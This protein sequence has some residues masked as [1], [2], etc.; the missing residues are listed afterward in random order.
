MRSPGEARG[1]AAVFLGIARSGAG[2]IALH[3]LRSVVTIACVVAL[4]LPYAVG[5]GIS[6]GLRAELLEAVRLGPDL[7]V[8]GTRFGRPAPLPASAAGRIRAIPGVTD[9]VPRIVGELEIGSDNESAVVVGLPADHLPDTLR[10]VE[11]RLFAPGAVGELVV[12]SELAARLGLSVGDVVPPFYR[13][14]AGERLTRVVG[15]F[16]SDAPLWQAHMLYVSLET[17]RLLFSEREAVTALVV[18]CPET[19]REPVAEQIRRLGTL[20]AEGELPAVRPR[21]TTRDDVQALL[22]RR[23]FDRETLFLLPL[24]L[25]FAVGIPII[26][27]TSGAGLVERRREAGLL[28]AIGWSTDAVLLRC[29]VESALLAMIGGGLAVLFAFIWLRLGNGAGIAAVLFPGADRLP[30]FRVPWRLGA[31]PVLLAL[32][33]SVVLV[34]AGSLFSTWRAAVAPSAEAMR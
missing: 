27:V 32:S 10:C 2:A 31:V 12:G 34:A 24:I 6:Y 21:V 9:V 30:G 20:G 7:H 26:L 33:I 14:E 1:A 22:L 23:V 3:P 13:N 4:V 15:I 16:R 18:R 19:Y 28:R 29:L 5:T 8:A 25:A 11:G 17:A